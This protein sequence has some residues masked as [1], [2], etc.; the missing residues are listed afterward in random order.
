[1]RG[2]RENTESRKLEGEEGRV[3]DEAEPTDLR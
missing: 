3:I 1:M 2:S